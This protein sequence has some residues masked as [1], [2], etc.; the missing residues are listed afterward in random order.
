[1]L[2]MLLLFALFGVA[3]FALYSYFTAASASNILGGLIGGGTGLVG[4][5]SAGYLQ[6]Q[7]YFEAAVAGTLGFAGWLLVAGMVAMVL[8]MAFNA[9]KTA[10]HNVTLVR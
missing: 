7:G 9:L 10:N 6:I 8:V 1:M 3:G 5:L 4:V 2:G